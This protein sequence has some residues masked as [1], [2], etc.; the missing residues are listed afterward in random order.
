MFWRI[1][2]GI[3]R[4]AQVS[5]IQTARQTPLISLK[6]I[7]GDP[8]KKEGKKNVTNISAAA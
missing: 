4:E 3:D 5:K 8:G 1:E 7:D 6:Y 2:I